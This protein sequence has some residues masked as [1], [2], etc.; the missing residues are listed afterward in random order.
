MK[1]LD[2]KWIINEGLVWFNPIFTN[3]TDVKEN[4]KYTRK[5]NK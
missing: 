2:E 5:H 3:T 1:K 4:L